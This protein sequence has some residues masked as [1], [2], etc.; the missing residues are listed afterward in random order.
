RTG[1]R[2][3]AEGAARGVLLRDRRLRRLPDLRPLCARRRCAARRA[4]RHRGV[5]LDHRRAPGLQPARRRAG[6]S[7]H[8]EGGIVAYGIAVSKDVMVKMRDGI[9]LATDVYRPA[10]DGELV[11]GQWPAIVCITPYDQTE[12]RY[13]EIAD[14][15]VPHGY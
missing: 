11:D 5:R 1:W 12:R 4:G 10:R 2:L 9:R 8:R 6:Q 13:T 3:R 15:F 14:F 7:D